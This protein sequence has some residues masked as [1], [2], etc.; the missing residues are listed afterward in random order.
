ML[1]LKV[2]EGSNDRSFIA[3]V[4]LWLRY[5]HKFDTWRAEIHGGG[6]GVMVQRTD[7]GTSSLLLTTRVAHM[8][9]SSGLRAKGT[10]FES[11]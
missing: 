6:N 3:S 1:Q 7:F 4:I 11:Q 8:S 5:G 2:W 10:L 9:L